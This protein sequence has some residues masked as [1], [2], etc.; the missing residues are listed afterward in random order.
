MVSVGRFFIFYV[1]VVHTDVLAAGGTLVG[2]SYISEQRMTDGIPSLTLLLSHN[3]PDTISSVHQAK[4]DGWGLKWRDDGSSTRER[5]YEEECVTYVCPRS[6]HLRQIIRE[7]K[8][9]RQHHLF[10]Y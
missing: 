8:Q 10:L 2:H 6:L 4:F 3:F 1:A 5:E 7:S 9:R